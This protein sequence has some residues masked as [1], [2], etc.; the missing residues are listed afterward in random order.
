MTVAV[1]T[2]DPS[3]SCC[4]NVAN[5]TCCRTALKREPAAEVLSAVCLSITALAYDC[6]S[7]IFSTNVFSNSHTRSTSCMNMSTY[8]CSNLNVVLGLSLEH[9]ISTCSSNNS[10]KQ[11]HEGLYELY[12]RCPKWRVSPPATHIIHVIEVRDRAII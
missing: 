1:I 10:S 9:V 2:C 6:C 8:C 4:S 12:E 3:Y 5:S 11:Q 7:Y